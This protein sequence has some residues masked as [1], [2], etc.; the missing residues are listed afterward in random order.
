MLTPPQKDL[1]RRIF[2]CI[3]EAEAK[4]HGTTIR[5]VHFHEVGAV[6]S[7]ADI[8]GVR[9]RPV[10]AGRRSDRLL[11]GADRHGLHRNR[12]RPRERAG[13]GDGRNAH[14][15]AAGASVVPLE[16]TTPTGAAIVATRGRRVRPAAGDDDPAASARAPATAT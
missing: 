5:K 8:V 11:A 15:R 12:A 2:T 16:L 3:G 10:A 9:G 13:P 7:I 14:G 4:V 1:A 6:D